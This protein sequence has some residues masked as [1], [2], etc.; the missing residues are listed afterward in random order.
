[1]IYVETGARRDF[2]NSPITTVAALKALTSVD[3]VIRYCVETDTVYRYEATGSAYT[4]DDLYVLITGD[5]GDTRWIGVSGRYIAGTLNV[6]GRFSYNITVIK[7]ATGNL[8]AAEVTN[9]IINNYGQGAETTLTLP[10]AAAGMNFM[11]VISTTGN[12]IHIKAGAS[13]KIY[14]DGTALDDGDKVSLA[15][16]AVANSATFY[17][18]QTGAAAWDWV[19]QTTLGVFTDGGA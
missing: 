6:S 12:A 3:N 15:T 16:P 4:A 18:I 9:T 8:S 10:A 11:L 5:G 14:L 2:Q 1:M 19:C 7:T 17:T 13:D